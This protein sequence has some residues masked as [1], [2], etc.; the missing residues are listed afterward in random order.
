M[1]AV[2]LIFAASQLAST[3]GSAL[4]ERLSGPTASRMLRFAPFGIGLAVLTMGLTA[5]AG[6]PATG[7]VAA[8]CF[9]LTQSTDGV[10]YP[11]WQ[12]RFNEAIPSAQRATILSISSAGFSLFMAGAFPAASYLPTIPLIYVVTGAVALVLALIWMVLRRSY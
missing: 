4:S 12:A 8:L 5:R 9:V 10:I 6:L 2:G 1:G 3:G 11:I 7:L